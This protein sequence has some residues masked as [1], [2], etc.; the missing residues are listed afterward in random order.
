MNIK[1]RQ[2]LKKVLIPAIDT[3]MIADIRL[4]EE[5]IK[6]NQYQGS[7]ILDADND[8]IRI[9]KPRPILKPGKKTGR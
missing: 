2:P 6:R 5:I 7:E 1:V 3:Q 4:V 8:F 9:K